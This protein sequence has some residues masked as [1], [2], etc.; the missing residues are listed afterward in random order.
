MAI[1]FDGSDSLPFDPSG[2]DIGNLS[3]FITC[4]F[5]NLTGTQFVLR[6]SA[7]TGD[8]RW[9]A[10]LLQG[11][12]NQWNYMYGVYSTTVTATANTN[13]NLHTMIAGATQGDFEAFLNGTSIGT[14]NLTTGLDDTSTDVGSQGGTQSFYNDHPRNCRVP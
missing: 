11:S 5:V 10:P 4:K 1:K 2:I 3:T 12:F 14:R 8:K 13:N 6:L 7:T 9:F